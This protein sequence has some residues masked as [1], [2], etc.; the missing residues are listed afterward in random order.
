[1]EAE[2][3]LDRRLWSRGKIKILI[4]DCIIRSFLR[5][6]PPS[7]NPVPYFVVVL[8]SIRKGWMTEWIFASIS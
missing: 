4:K 6:E 8:R 3:T 5:F 7:C 1:M 2:T